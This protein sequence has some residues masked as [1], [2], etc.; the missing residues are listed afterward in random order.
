MEPCFRLRD[1]TVEPYSN[2]LVSTDT[3][4]QV[5]VEPKVMQVLQVLAERAGETVSKE[6]LFERV[7]GGPRL[8]DDVLTVTISALRKALGDSARAPRFVQTVPGSGYRLIVPV[9]AVDADPERPVFRLRHALLGAAV[10]LSTALVWTS[11]LRT[12]EVLSA[13]RQPGE[14]RDR[15]VEARYLLGR[16]EPAAT[17]RA[18]ELL[19]EVLLESPEFT[20]ARVAL[21]EAHLLAAELGPTP[22]ESLTAARREAQAALALEE[23]P[24]ARAILAQVRFAL[25]WDLTGA[26]DDFRHALSLDP[27]NACAHLGLGAVL[28]ARGE[29]EEALVHVEEY[30][31]LD[32]LA[33]PS[34]FR[35]FVL[36]SLG[37]FDEALADLTRLAVNAPEDPGLQI[38]LARVSAAANRAE[39]CFAA[40]DRYYE[41]T[42]AGDGVRRKFRARFEADGLRGV[43]LFILER[44]DER[45]TAG[46]H[47]SPIDRAAY[48]AFAGQTDAALDWLERAYAERDLGLPYIA[49]RPGFL[50]LREDPRFVAL[51]ARLG[52]DS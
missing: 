20:D 23:S 33:Y 32:P 24:A 47:V 1:W 45:S 28:L 9:E 44:L 30:G 14:L 42:G 10:L 50:K 17:A 37:R 15:T 21:A 35:A 16:R 38:Y 49:E 8:T 5:R 40:Y 25:D 12:P 19:D 13:E 26:E 22:Q 27:Q 48:H 46:G 4:R 39:D 41:L 31:R 3:G 52:R 2:R 18:R 51:L 36:V 11:L 43:H 6:E 29:P 34:P 7:W